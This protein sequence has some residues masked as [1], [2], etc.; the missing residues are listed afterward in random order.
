MNET[1]VIKDILAGADR[2]EELVKRYHVGLIIHCDAYVHDRAAAEDIAQEAFIAAYRNL[3]TFDT[4]RS[5]FSTW[6][7]RIAR[8]LAIDYLR[9]ENRYIQVDDIESV[10]AA[11][12]P[13]FLEEEQKQEVRVAVQNLMPPEYSQVVRAYYWEGKSYQQIASDMQVP[14][15][16]VRTWLRRAKLQLQGQLS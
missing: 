9:R 2:Y 7:Y 1:E 10:A 6:L 16:T 13:A 4:E 8:N 11:T 3:Q 14:L 12:L 15:N 5:R